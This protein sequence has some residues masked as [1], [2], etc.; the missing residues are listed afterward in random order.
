MCRKTEPKPRS[1][2]KTEPKHTDFF[3][4]KRHSNSKYVV[5]WL[6]QN[7]VEVKIERPLDGHVW[8]MLPVAQTTTRGWFPYGSRGRFG[9]DDG[10]S[11]K[12]R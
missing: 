9:S 1:G 11:F 8:L 3:K 6:L 12:A 7:I 10:W 2:L 4:S 5:G